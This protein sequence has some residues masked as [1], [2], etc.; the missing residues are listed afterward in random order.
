MTPDEVVLELER[1]R[2]RHCTE[3]LLCLGDQPETAFKSYRETLRAFGHET[4]VDYL[5]WSAMQAL[6]RGLLPHTNA[7]VLEYD[8]MR[9]LRRYNVSLGLMLENVSERLCQRGGPHHRAPDK[10]PAR[11]LRMLR[12]AG[13]LAIPFT[14]GILVGIGETPRERVETLLAIRRVHREHGHVQEVIVQNFTPHCGTPMANSV[15]AGD[16]EFIHAVALA[17]LVLDPEVGVQAPPNLNPTRTERLLAAGINDFGGISP[18]TKDYINPE[19]PWPELAALA[20]RCKNA[21]FELAPR[22]AIHPWCGKDTKFLD[23]ALLPAVRDAH[24]RLGTARFLA[25]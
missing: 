16:D 20:A 25:S 15:P 3:A 21:G 9:R 13:E 5:E 1:A 17:R 23:P 10:R 8:D 4:T 22:L 19:Q 14:T 11:R 12:E 7:G 2:A 6:E 24:H 18:V